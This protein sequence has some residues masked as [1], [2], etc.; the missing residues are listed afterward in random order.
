MCADTAGHTTGHT[1]DVKNTAK[2]TE[3]QLGWMLATYTPRRFTC[4]AECH[5][6]VIDFVHTWVTAGACDLPADFSPTWEAL[7]GTFAAHPLRRHLDAL[8]RDSQGG[9]FSGG[10]SSDG[11]ACGGGASCHPWRCGWLAVMRA[12]DFWD[13]P[14]LYWHM[15]Y[16]CHERGPPGRSPR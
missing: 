4:S 11:G 14:C 1:D 10:A 7:V 9:A 15:V 8:W 12:A 5:E 16:L 2:H 6:R 3:P 13:V